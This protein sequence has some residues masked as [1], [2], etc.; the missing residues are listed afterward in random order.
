MQQWN[1][2]QYHTFKIQWKTM[3]ERCKMETSKTTIHDCLLSW[4]VMDRIDLLSKQIYI[5]IIP[6]KC[7][8]IYL[9]L[10]RNKQLKQNSSEHLNPT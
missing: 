9:E 10:T 4:L 2:S 6:K 5:A 1:E 8:K 7:N 3:V